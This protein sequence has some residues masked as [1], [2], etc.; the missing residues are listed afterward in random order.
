MGLIPQKRKENIDMPVSKRTFK[1][2]TLTVTLYSKESLD[3]LEDNREYPESFLSEVQF[4]S[5]KGDCV[6]Q[7]VEV[8][9]EGIDALSLVQA[10][11]DEDD[12]VGPLFF[13]LDLDGSDHQETELYE[14]TKIEKTW[15]K[16]CV[17]AKSYE[18]AEALANA[19]HL[20]A[21]HVSLEPEHEMI[22]QKIEDTL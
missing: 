14:I 21:H 4:L 6:L 9:E 17:N 5:E 11:E 19:G 3:S 16:Y 7:T 1:K 15:K 8:K 18:Q 10:L 20:T 22:I 2:T 12:R 13:D